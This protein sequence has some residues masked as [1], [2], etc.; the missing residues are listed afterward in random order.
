[1][2]M[3]RNKF[4]ALLG[5][6]LLITI[7]SCSDGYEPKPV[8]FVSLD[9]VFSPTDSLGTNAVKFLSNIYAGLQ[10]G[11]NRVGGDYLDAASDD[12]VSINIS[13]P[14][15]YKL[16]VGQYTAISRTSNM[17]WGV[18]YQGIR[19]VNILL[20]N[21]DVVPFMQTYVNAKGESHPL[22]VSMKAEAR[23]LRACFYFELVKRYGG[24][25]LMGDDIH[26]LGDDM[27]L[28]RNT[29]ED[30]IRYIVDE[31]DAIKDDLRTNP[32]PDF[33]QYS[34][35]ATREVC[36]AM[37]ARV[38]LYA[39]SPL[40]NERPIEPGNELIGYAS[41]DR[42]RWKEAAKAAKEFI[43]E[44]GP[45]GK[46]V[47]GLNNDFRDVFLNFYNVT[48]NPEVIFYRPGSENTSIEN[49]NGPLGFS[50]NS[51]GKGRTLPTQNLVDAFPMKDGMFA[52]QGSKYVKN[53]EDPYLNCDPRL[54]YTVLHHGSLWLR[55]KLDTSKG[56]ANNPSGVAEYTR[57]SYYMCKFMGKFETEQDYS[58]KLH[59]WIMYRYAEILLNYAEAE[60]ESLDTP[61]SDVY[62]AIIALRKRAGI[63]AGENNYGLKEVGEMTQDQMRELIHNE[64][65]IELAFE[66]HRYWDI[67]RWRS[68]ENIFRNPLK[69]L[70]IKT[71]GGKTSFININVLQTT[72]DVNRYFYPIPYSE[73]V[74][75]D[76]MIQNPNW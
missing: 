73:V 70:E 69:G 64:R 16:Q 35:A 57:T 58:N 46:A 18:Y 19:K 56:G 21:I 31:L 36:M 48:A 49:N 26:V 8:E 30:C 59:L 72:F 62:D 52:D 34:H 53:Q 14:D 76:N 66:E 25:P 3:I 45:E 54:D 50:G 23:F 10:N 24:V 2:F 9:F 67:R 20:D 29:F 17:D 65:R 5:A 1:M 42:N 74:K 38:L 11:H 27:E 33:D 7:T 13:D 28:P 22:N 6:S 55:N 40:F 51:L 44:Y 41:Y 61:S 68:A 63:E 71:T 15:V 75:N 32:M 43:D 12:A 60:N 37:K 4:L 39:A 47:Y